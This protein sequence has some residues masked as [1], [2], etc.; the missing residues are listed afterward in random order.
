[1]ETTTEKSITLLLAK[2]KKEGEV[3]NAK[4]KEQKAILDKCINDLQEVLVQLIE[5]DDYN[6]YFMSNIPS[7]EEEKHLLSEEADIQL[8]ITSS[9]ETV[10]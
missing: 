5:E 6:K 10:A 7:E 8:S 4:S 3:I 2:W 1:M 9:H